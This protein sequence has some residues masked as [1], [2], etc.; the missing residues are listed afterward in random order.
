VVRSGQMALA[1][2]WVENEDDREYEEE[3]EEEGND[4]RWHAGENEEWEEDELWFG[5]R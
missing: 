2:S 3:E 5:W 4:G 1:R